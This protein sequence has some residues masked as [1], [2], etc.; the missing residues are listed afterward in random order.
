MYYMYEIDLANRLV[1]GNIFVKKCDYFVLLNLHSFRRMSL[2]KYELETLLTCREKMNK[3]KQFNNRE[4]ELYDRLVAKKQ[5]ISDDLLSDFLEGKELE[6]YG[7]LRQ[8]KQRISRV[9]ISPSFACNF[10]CAYC[11]QRDFQSKKDFLTPDAIDNVCETLK[12]IN[13][14]DC[15]LDGI[16]HVVINGGEPLQEPNVATIN[17]IIECFAKPGIDL[18]LMTNGYNILKFKDQIDFS[19]FAAVQ[20]SLDNIDPY[21]S[22]INGVGHPVFEEVINSLSYL[23]ELECK[24]TIATIM[25]KE[26]LANLDEFVNRLTAVGV[27]ENERCSIDISPVVSFGKST[28]NS[29]F[30]TINEFIE[31]KRILASKRLPHN[32]R[33]ANLPEARWISRAINR[34]TNERI[35]GKPSMCSIQRN[36]SIHFAPNGQVY[37]CLCVDPDKGSLGSFYP[38]LYINTEGIDR[39]IQKSVYSDEKCKTCPYKFLCSSGCP[40]H[41]VAATGDYSKPFCGFFFDPEFWRNL[42]E[43]L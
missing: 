13:N 20:V 38:S 28:L 1:F 3:G 24:V 14:S 4:K 39:C 16:T 37:W 7:N 30:Y 23:M 41:A 32:L 6:H 33:I 42:E 8:I 12:S 11:Y 15:Y 2:N 19:K 29:S 36:R 27:V 21:A 35:Y 10:N 25:T 40:L 26:L 9:T 17:H 22:I 5:I 31:A 34:N 43:L 18:S